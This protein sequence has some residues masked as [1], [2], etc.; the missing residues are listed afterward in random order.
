VGNIDP[1]QGALL[2]EYGFLQWP[3][4]SNLIAF[5]FSRNF[6]CICTEPQE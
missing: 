2:V 1:W 6:C 5:P 3:N 4:P